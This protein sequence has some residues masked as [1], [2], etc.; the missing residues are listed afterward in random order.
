MSLMLIK[1][2]E[3]GPTPRNMRKQLGEVRRTTW[4]AMGSHWHRNIR[5]KHFTVA[6]AREYGYRERTKGYMKMKQ[7]KYG[8]QLPLVM[9]G[10]SRRATQIGRITA[11]KDRVRVT[12]TA[13]RLNWS[14]GQTKPREELT[15]ISMRDRDVLV[16]VGDRAMGAAF[17]S[18]KKRRSMRI[19]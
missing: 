5:P 16:N 14:R 2:N 15:R 6:G 4:D 9:T 8:H 7:R 11:T 12:M 10:Q 19:S 13:P 17:K 3:D 1:I 18:I